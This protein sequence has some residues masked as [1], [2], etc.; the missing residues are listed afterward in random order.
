MQLCC[1]VYQWCQQIVSVSGLCMPTNDCSDGIEGVGYITAI[2]QLP[3]HHHAQNL[4]A[5]V[6]LCSPTERPLVLRVS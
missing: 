4:F 6:F 5:I 3:N 2:Q 1:T